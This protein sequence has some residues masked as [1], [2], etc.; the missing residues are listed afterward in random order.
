MPED[1]EPNW[2]I[3]PENKALVE[4]L[5]EIIKARREHGLLNNLDDEVNLFCGFIAGCQACG[6]EGPSSYA[7]L[8]MAGRS[9]FQPEGYKPRRKR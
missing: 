7:I 9:P 4:R 1:K 6:M 8:Y 3:K 2:L 5:E